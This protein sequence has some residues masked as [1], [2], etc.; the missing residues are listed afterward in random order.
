MNPQNKAKVAQ[1]LKRAQQ[2]KQQAR[3]PKPIVETR[4][5]L[6]PFSASPAKDKA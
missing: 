6:Q 5:S 1:V 3:K 4:G 2:I